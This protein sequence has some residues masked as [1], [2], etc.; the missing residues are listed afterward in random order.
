MVEKKLYL[1]AIA[2]TLVVFGIAMVFVRVYDDSKL[3]GLQQGVDSTAADTDETRLLLIY[4]QVFA[5]KNTT[6]LCKFLDYNINRQSSRGYYLVRTLREQEKNNLLA[7]YD[8]TK[9]KYYL[10]NFEIWLYLTQAAQTC[11]GYDITPAL[12]FTQTQTLCADCIVQG[13]VL[14]QLRGECKNLRVIT[15]ADDLDIA[16]ISLVKE[17][18]GVSDSPS[19]VINNQQVLAGLQSRESILSKIRCERQ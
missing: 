9:K 19:L 4:S 18:F 11:P 12:F 3:G 10:N 5:Q 13:D 8:E 7:N 16:P 2:V 6:S 15:L 14:D 1:G 17:T